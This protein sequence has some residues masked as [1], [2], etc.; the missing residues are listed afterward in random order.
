[1]L[2]KYVD[3]W[4]SLNDL[5]RQPAARAALAAN[6]GP[7]TLSGQSQKKK[8]SVYKIWGYLWGGGGNFAVTVCWDVTLCDLI[9][10]Y[11]LSD[12]HLPSI[13]VSQ[14]Q[15][16]RA[17]PRPLVRTRDSMDITVTK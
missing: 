16:H 7:A 9:D 8:I 3:S 14:V 4:K 6:N 15:G 10:A 2:P 5:P 17:T 13:P 1:L 12:K 11:Q